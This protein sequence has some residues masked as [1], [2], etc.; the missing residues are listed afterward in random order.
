MK[1]LIALIIALCLLLSLGLSVCAADSEAELA[2]K[3]LYS[4]GLMNGVGTLPDG[5]IDFGLDASLTREQAAIMLLR[6]L[7]KE[8]EGTD[9]SMP[10][11]DVSPWA[12]QDVAYAYRL[13][14]V[15]GT[16]DHTFGGRDAVSPAMYISFVLR[17]LGYSSESDFVWSSP[18]TLSDEIGLTHGEYNEATTAFTRA[19]MALISSWALDTK[20]KGSS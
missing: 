20:M 18:W 12:R 8:A 15:K 3:R 11:K 13:G 5:S 17:A 19:D 14:L 7:G 16:G 9:L 2:A 10:F 4:L 6:L 1:K